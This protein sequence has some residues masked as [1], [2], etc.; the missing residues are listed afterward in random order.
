MIKIESLDTIIMI[1]AFVIGII[2]GRFSIYIK[3]LTIS[4]TNDYLYIE[5][6]KYIIKEENDDLYNIP[7]KTKE[8]SR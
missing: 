2:A 3:I 5:N 1:I 7:I 6:R 8:H 4:D